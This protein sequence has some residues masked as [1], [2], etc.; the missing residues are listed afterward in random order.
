[1][2]VVNINLPKIKSQNSTYA[3]LTLEAARFS[4]WV[5]YLRDREQHL[6][7]ELLFTKLAALT[8]SLVT[9]IQMQGK[10]SPEELHLALRIDNFF[11]LVS[12]LSEQIEVLYLWKHCTFMKGR[13]Q[14]Y[15]TVIY[16]KKCMFGLRSHSCHRATKTLGIS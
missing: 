13:S 16:H 1:M 7:G 10:D 8:D 3:Y 4:R 14:V 12:A 11:F 9:G 5:N 6:C 2:R 15:D